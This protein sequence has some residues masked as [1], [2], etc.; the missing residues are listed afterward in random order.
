MAK[1]GREVHSLASLTCCA[2]YLCY[3]VTEVVWTVCS[4]PAKQKSSDVAR[5]CCKLPLV[6]AGGSVGAAV[7]TVIW[8]GF[9]TSMGVLAGELAPALYV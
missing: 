2:G 9:G 5:G 1:L 3:H 6:L 7:G 8:P 4:L